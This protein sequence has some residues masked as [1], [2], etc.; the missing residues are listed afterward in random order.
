MA[1]P[2]KSSP[3]KPCQAPRTV[4]T[5]RNPMPSPATRRRVGRSSDRATSDSSIPHRGEV[6][7][8]MPARVDG[9]VSSA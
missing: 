3:E 9:I 1:V 6:A 8:Q 5:P 4:S 7:L 2:P